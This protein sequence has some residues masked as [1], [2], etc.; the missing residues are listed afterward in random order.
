MAPASGARASLRRPQ[1]LG[2]GLPE[3]AGA[4]PCRRLEIVDRLDPVEL[5]LETIELGAERRDRSAV[6]RPVAIALRED[7]SAPVR[8]RLVS[9]FPDRVEQ[10]GDLVMRH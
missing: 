1:A 2:R 4:L 3:S 10:R 6:A 9:R 8:H 7:L 5:A